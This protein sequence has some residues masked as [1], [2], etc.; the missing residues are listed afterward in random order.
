[1]A[2][3]Y[4]FAEMRNLIKKLEYIQLQTR[5][6]QIRFILDHRNEEGQVIPLKG[7]ATLYNTSLRKVYAVKRSMNTGT[8]ETVPESHKVKGRSIL[9][10][11]EKEEVYL[12]IHR[13]H[14]EKD[15]PSYASVRE[16]FR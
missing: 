2:N 5:E 12:W 4:Y 14:I 15:Y 9:T 16:K 1:M 7:I 11:E 8:I 6:E 3:L 10:Y 13:K